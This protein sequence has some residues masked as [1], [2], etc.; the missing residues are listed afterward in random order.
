MTALKVPDFTINNAK[1]LA[2]FLAKAQDWREIQLLTTAYPQWKDEAWYSLGKKDQ[3]K[4]KKL[5]KWSDHPIAK[6]FPLGSSVQ[7]I[8]DTEEQWGQ[9]VD[10]WSAYGVEYVTFQIGTDTDWCQANQL[11]RSY[12]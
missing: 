6:K 4:I 8:D 3:E 2:E 10:Y 1:E 11:K 5:K 12:Q 7:R 9:V